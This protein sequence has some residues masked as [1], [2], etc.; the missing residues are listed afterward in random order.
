MLDM[1]V[2]VIAEQGHHGSLCV[3]RCQDKRIDMPYAPINGTSYEFD[4]SRLSDFAELAG[5][6]QE[7]R[8]Q[9]RLSPDV[10]Y[11]IRKHFRIKN[12]YHSNAIEGNVLAVG[13]T[14]Q[15]VEHGLT[16]TGKP[17]KDQAEARNLSHALDFL[18]ELAA[19]SRTPITEGD[20]RQLHAL[21][22]DGLS[23]EAGSYRSVPVAISGSEFSPPG[24]E[25]VSADMADFARW[26]A[27]V[28]VPDP[29]AFAGVSGLVAA[30][31]AHTWFVTVHPFI[32]GN[33]RVARLLM[34]LLLMRHGYPI[35][36]ITKEDRLRYYDALELSQASDLTP[37][38]VLVAECVEESLEEYEAAAEEQR[39]QIEWAASLADK[40]TKPERIR[41]EN[42]YEVWKNAM[43]LLKSFLQQTADD[44][45]DQAKLYGNVYLKD[46]GS[47]EFEKYA[48]LRRGISA[49]RT[50]FL[51]IDFRRGDTTVRY[52]FFFGHASRAMERR[53]DVTLH[54]AR[55]EPPGSFHYERLEDIGSMNVPD[56]A[57][58]GYEMEGERFVVRVRNGRPR[59]RR[60]EDFG[61]RFFND[62][63]EKHFA[64]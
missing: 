62:V 17:L 31:A 28:S 53:C 49:K 22:L 19:N 34:N 38:I 1:L 16:I 43:E 27:V 63:M 55:E 45:A 37:F 52:L 54:V 7:M 5:R 14:R 8:A 30:A 33:G 39:V 15:V 60:V 48:A 23:D 18:E 4:D 26:L 58:I 11:R 47:L 56:L 12:I 25:S 10:L 3:A 13:E 41:A 36:I 51:R 59:I 29:D 2:A 61:K 20:V 44:L 32:D 64:G 35:A 57:E 42:E 40:F 6:V 21:V 46:F 24:P 50:W 9:G